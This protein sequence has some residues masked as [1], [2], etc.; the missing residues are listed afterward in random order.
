MQNKHDNSPNS[1]DGEQG[2]Y[3][4]K[5]YAKRLFDILNKKPISRRMAATEL[6]YADQTYMVTQL[7]S[8]WLKANKAAVFGQIKCSR[9]RRWVEAITTNPDLFPKSNQLKLF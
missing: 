7:I 9:S 4:K 3:T 1:F 5:E 8:D 6:G 2:K